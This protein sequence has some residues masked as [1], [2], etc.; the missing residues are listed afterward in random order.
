MVSHF[1]EQKI[2]PVAKNVKDFE[3]LMYSEYTYIILLETHIA[4]LPSLMKLAKQNQKKVLLHVD[5][6]QGLK[7]DEYA[8]EYLCQI[9][10]P[11]GLISTR[12]PVVRIAKKRKKI[13]IQRV[14]L[15][16]THALETSYRVID[17]TQPDYIEILPG[18]VPPTIIKEVHQHSSVP[19]LAGG[20]IRTHTE[21]Q[22]A[23]KA[24]ALAVTTSEKKLWN[25][26]IN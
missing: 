21:V 8:A 26:K 6:V 16:D 5:L 23:L 14:F 3:T 12:A 10:K 4:Q 7:S 15:L 17:S 22:D 9:V 25:R 2:L 11:D 24:G 13:A 1:A 18:V 19:I 20:L